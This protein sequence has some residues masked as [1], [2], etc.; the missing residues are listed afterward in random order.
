MTAFHRIYPVHNL[1]HPKLT[2]MAPLGPIDFVE[3]LGL[4]T[5]GP[6]RDNPNIILR[7][8]KFNFQPVVDL[9]KKEIPALFA[10]LELDNGK[11]YRRSDPNLFDHEL[12]EL[13]EVFGPEIWPDDG[14]RSHL[15]DPDP[16]SRY[17]ADLY[18]PDDKEM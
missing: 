2:T 8:P 15:R 4:A 11:K 18:Y 12:D 9:Y 13:L 6:E 5:F 1:Q 14:D 10:M 17:P 3:A 16:E 7:K